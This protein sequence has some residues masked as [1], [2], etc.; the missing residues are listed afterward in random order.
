MLLDFL[1]L[2]WDLYNS[3]VFLASI[4]N[5][6]FLA[7]YS[8]SLE[9]SNPQSYPSGMRTMNQSKRIL[10]LTHLY[11]QVCSNISLQETVQMLP[12]RANLTRSS[13]SHHQSSDLWKKS[14]PIIG[15]SGKWVTHVRIFTILNKIEVYLQQEG[16]EWTK[17]WPFQAMSSAYTCRANMDSRFNVLSIEMAIYISKNTINRPTGF[18]MQ[19]KCWHQ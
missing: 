6:N 4:Y 14:I 2:F 11:D 8:W 3:F 17:E 15:G 16:M 10:D 12:T 18:R 13:Y 1:S 9:S 19:N 5:Y 7:N